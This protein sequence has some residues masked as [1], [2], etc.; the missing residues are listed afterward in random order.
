MKQ[1]PLKQDPNK[2]AAGPMARRMILVCLLIGILPALAYSPIGPIGC[3]ILVI[4]ALT[5]ALVWKLD[6]RQH[7]ERTALEEV[8]EILRRLSAMAAG[9]CALISFFC[10]A[11]FWYAQ[12]AP[13][14][15]S[16]GPPQS[17]ALEL[18]NP[19]AEQRLLL[20]CAFFCALSL[21]LKWLARWRRQTEELAELEEF[22][23]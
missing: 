6:L 5:L 1:E 2:L 21:T 10:G 18:R 16:L 8:T 9:I 13:I 11:S 14:T 15:A 17:V 7:P 4:T 20:S 12:H 22:Y 3:V 23:D 19:E